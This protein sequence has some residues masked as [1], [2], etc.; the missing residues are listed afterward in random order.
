MR[1]GQGT[2]FQQPWFR[3][4]AA[5]YITPTT[6]ASG[7]P[8][9]EAA[10][11]GAARSHADVMLDHA[12]SGARIGPVPLDPRRVQMVYQGATTTGQTSRRNCTDDADEPVRT[13]WCL[14]TARG[15]TRSRPLRRRGLSV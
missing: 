1:L 11:T 13:R 4:S 8:R 2:A 7:G 10:G 3:Q 5:N 6:S 12:R 15:A 14:P 9:G